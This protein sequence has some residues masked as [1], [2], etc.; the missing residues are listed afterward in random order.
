D[1]IAYYGALEDLDRATFDRALVWGEGAVTVGPGT[2]T[3]KPAS[4]EEIFSTARACASCGTGVP[5]LDPR[6]FS[7]NTKQ[8]R[9]E[10]CEGAGVE[11]GPAALLEEERPEPCEACE[12]SRLS[13][14]PRAVRLFGERYHEATG[15]PVPDAAPAA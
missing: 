2:P 14:L 8:G 5:E 10:A 7:F 13:P 3:A 15:R 6:W 4:G 9:C 12:G 1:L 11:G